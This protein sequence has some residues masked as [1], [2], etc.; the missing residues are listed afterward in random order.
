MER[1]ATRPLWFRCNNLSYFCF[2]DGNKNISEIVP[3]QPV[4]GVSA[5]Y[6][7]TPFGASDA[8]TEDTINVATMNPFR[9]SSE[10]TD[11]AIGLSC[12][13]TRFYDT[14]SGRWT[15]RDLIEDSL[16]DFSFVDNDPVSYYDVHGQKKRPANNANRVGHRSMKNGGNWEKHT[17][18]MGYNGGKKPNFVVGGKRCRSHMR[19]GNV[20]IG[21]MGRLNA[22]MAGFSV[23]EVAIHQMGKNGMFDQRKDWS[24]N[25]LGDECCEPPRHST[26]VGIG[27]ISIPFAHC[28]RKGMNV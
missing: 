17:R 7:Y 23:A 20:R 14:N 28:V 27:I 3:C 10:Y 5:H 12:Y 15:S 8:I 2:T 26:I 4:Y 19:T 1:V 13:I 9:F 22:V 6:E 21:L 16:S 18:A 11:D 24:V 25:F